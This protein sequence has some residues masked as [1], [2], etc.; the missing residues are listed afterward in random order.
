MAAC[1]TNTAGTNTICAVITTVQSIAIIADRAVKL[2]RIITPAAPVA[3]AGIV[4]ALVRGVTVVARAYASAIHTL[5]RMRTGIAVDTGRAVE[6]V[7][8]TTTA[9]AIAVPRID[10]ARVPTSTGVGRAAANAVRTHVR[11]RTSN[12][13][14]TARAIR[15]VRI[16]TPAAPVAGAGIV[17]ALVRAVTGIGRAAATAIRTLVRR[18]TG[19]SVVAERAIGYV[20]ISTPAA[21]VAGAGIVLALVAGKAGICRSGASTAA[22]A[23]VGIGTDITVIAG[24]DIGLVLMS[25]DL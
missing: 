1:A 22:V 7:R 21:P 25:A 9:A 18:R 13:V 17:L 19:I 4:L 15:L 24:G 14:V 11:I 6:L 2:I 10:L 3:G 8:I 5:V 16:S 20:R 12:A 23:A